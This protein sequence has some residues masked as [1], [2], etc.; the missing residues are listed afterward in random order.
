MDPSQLETQPFIGADELA[1]GW[2]TSSYSP[3]SASSLDRSGTASTLQD[4]QQP[5]PA[6]EN[7]DVA[8]CAEVPLQES[9]P[10]E[11]PLQLS[12][13]TLP[14]PALPTQSAVAE[15]LPDT[16]PPEASVPSEVAPQPAASLP[17]EISPQPA[18]SLP[19]EVKEALHPGNVAQDVQPTPVT[20][21]GKE[22]EADRDAAPKSTHM[23][24]VLE[25]KAGVMHVYSNMYSKAMCFDTCRDV[26]FSCEGAPLRTQQFAQEVEQDE[27]DGG[28]TKQRGGRGRGRGRGNGRGGKGK[29]KGRGGGKSAAKVKP[30]KAAG[31]KGRGGKGRGGRGRAGKECNKTKAKAKAAAKSKGRATKVK[32]KK[33]HPQEGHDEDL[34]TPTK[35]P[36]QDDDQ[37][38][39]APKRS[40]PGG[41]KRTLAKATPTDTSKSPEEEG[42]AAPAKTAEEEGAAAEVPKRKKKEPQAKAKVKANAKAAAKKTK[43]QPATQPKAKAKCKAKAQAS[44]RASKGT[45]DE[46]KREKTFARRYRPDNAASAVQWEAMRDAFNEHVRATVLSPSKL[47]ESVCL[48]ML[49]GIF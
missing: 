17:S 28:L 30:C 9:V 40:P 21:P 49:K 38:L 31:G 27:G 24:S 33:E 39:S 22:H 3:T 41:T 5:M 34:V 44:T 8:V 15:A 16:P 23:G 26:S 4:E 20:D 19:S 29:G 10:M 1:A 45:T 35:K 13:S 12:G 37:Q 42:T 2:T 43:K 6:P 7:Q 47:E 14:E 18:A 11:A 48:L 36:K 25:F 46:G 32:G